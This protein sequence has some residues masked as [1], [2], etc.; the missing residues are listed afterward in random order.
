MKKADTVS[1]IVPTL[2]H[3]VSIG[4]TMESLLKQEDADVEVL[5][6]D[7]GSTDRTL[8]VLQEYASEKISVFSVKGMTHYQ[9]FNKGILQAQGT[10]LAFLR[11]GDRYLLP[12]TTALMMELAKD[13]QYPAYVYCGAYLRA[14]HGQAQTV[15]H[16]LSELKIGVLPTV[17]SCVIVKTQE[18]NFLYL[19]KKPLFF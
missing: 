10:Y 19:A 8:R 14:L 18:N 9:A 17:L 3:A 5:V 6:I 4:T 16:P 12:H 2:N 1:I 11:P 15:L 7:R 13:N